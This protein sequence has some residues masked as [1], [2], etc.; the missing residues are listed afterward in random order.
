VK[1]VFDGRKSLLHKENAMVS[2]SLD[3]ATDKDLDARRIGKSKRELF[4]CR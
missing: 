4:G 2:I 1:S 3:I